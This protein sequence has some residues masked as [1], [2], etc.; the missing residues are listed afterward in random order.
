MKTRIRTGL[1]LTF[2]VVA[3]LGGPVAHIAPG[4]GTAEAAF[5]TATRKLLASD[6]QADDH[7]G[8]RV[9]ISNDTA[10][11][12][13]WLE[14]SL[15]SNAGAAY[16]FERHADGTDNWGEVKKL[17]APGGGAD[18]HFGLGVAVDDDTIVI[19][20]RQED[21][22]AIN[23]GSAYVF[24]RNLGGIGNWGLSRKIV[25]SDPGGNDYFGGAVA[26]DGDIITVGATGW[27]TGSNP[28]SNGAAYVFERNF[29]GVN[30][31]GEVKR[32]NATTLLLVDGFGS[33]VA[34][35]GEVIIV[36]AFHFFDDRPARAHVFHRDHGG[37]NNWGE[38]KQLVP[39]DG[40]GFDGFGSSLALDGDT[41]IVGAYRWNDEGAAYVYERHEG[42]PDNWGEVAK[43]RSFDI[44]WGDRFGES[45]ALSGDTAVVGA[46]QEDTDGAQAGRAYTFDRDQGG[47]DGWGE[48]STLAASGTQQFDFYGEV[49]IDS[50]T[51]M[52]GAHGEDTVGDDGGAAYIF[53]LA[54]L[55][56]TPTPTAT[57]T[58]TPTPTNTPPPTW[59]PIQTTPEPVGGVALATE[60]QAL[61]LE[62]SR[63][64]V[65][66]DVLLWTIGL[67]TYIVA[68]SALVWRIRKVIR[69]VNHPGENLG[70]GD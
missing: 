61:L 48:V 58:D 31:W 3:M 51:V 5:L 34:V 38:V 37:V 41:A 60:S 42:G 26:I 23:A 56:S 35:D 69:S 22:A 33:S 49:A 66:F 62:A 19:G 39:S 10:V 64:S 43:L 24:E 25:A 15:G 57:S 20:A 68:S 9:A 47:T 29:G 13:A 67:A 54:G 14:D 46:P 12:G 8:Q 45:V 7:F 21:S 16:V 30:A 27:D 53:D 28:L 55:K 6:A 50:D 59:T 44:Q 70:E 65:G 11:V 36:N 17:T 32:L 52:V 1:L 40:H 18:D 4:P 2:L 63:A